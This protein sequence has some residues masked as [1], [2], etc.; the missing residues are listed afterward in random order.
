VACAV[1]DGR[2]PGTTGDG[3]GVERATAAGLDV[4]V[5]AVLWPPSATANVIATPAAPRT[6]ATATAPDRKLI[7]SMRA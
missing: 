1:A 4:L 7:S 3:G 2:A 5:A 6:P